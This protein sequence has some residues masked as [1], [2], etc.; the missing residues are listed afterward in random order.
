MTHNTSK[1]AVLSL[2]PMYAQQYYE[3]VLE[4]NIYHWIVNDEIRMQM[5]E[6]IKNPPIVL[7]ERFFTMPVGLKFPK[8]SFVFEPIKKALQRIKEAGFF[9]HL[10]KQFQ[11]DPKKEEP[12]K[13]EILT[14]SQL[15]VGFYIWMGSL[16]IAIA[17]FFA[18]RIISKLSRASKAFKVKAND[19]VYR[20]LVETILKH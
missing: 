10:E 6:L 7:K 1:L 12:G 9:Q 11:T 17:G 5:K 8:D 15:A 14:V 19:I 20:Y 2:D 13:P 4:N 18:E 16:I 3:I